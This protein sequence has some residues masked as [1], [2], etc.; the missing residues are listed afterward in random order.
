VD[1]LSLT[2][3]PIPR[4]LHLALSGARDTS[5]INTPPQS[6]LP[7]QTEIHNWSEEL[8]RDAIYREMDRQGQAFFV[9]N[10]VQSIKAVQGMLQRVAPGVKYAVAH[11]QMPERDLERVMI[12]FLDQKWDVLV[13][14]MIIESGLDMPNVNTLLVN[15]ADR[16][17]LAQL[18]QL[19]GRIGRSN[20]QAYAYLLTPPRLAM[21]SE[22]RK[23]L[24]TLAELTEL[25]SG[26]KVA[27]R[28][29][30]IRGA[31]N[32][33][34]AEQ[35]GFINAV[36][37]DLYAR[38][39]E[40]AV[41]EIRDERPLAEELQIQT[42]VEIAAPALFPADYIE[43]GDLRYDLYRRLAQASRVAQVDALSGEIQDRFGPLPAPAWNLLQVAAV[44]LLGQAVGFRRISLNDAVLT[45]E[46]VL[47]LDPSSRQLYIGRLVAASA[48]DQVE[49]RAHDQVELVHRLKSGNILL[50]TR[51]FLQRLEENHIL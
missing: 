22:A 6:R 42:Q 17:G 4:T 30:E 45:A 9:H 35:S 1:V 14:T 44:K 15:R 39:L 13:T 27:L 36:G 49:F 21:T 41:A 51:N 3:T 25:G 16:F 31:G 18:Y 28:D 2:A 34:G 8:I 10:R 32:L 43:D 7:V 24:A 46:L 5:Q 47:P 12:E 33:L 37:F 11:G 19:R 48:P 20:R 26:L 40:E 50:Q 23:R 38:M 29:L